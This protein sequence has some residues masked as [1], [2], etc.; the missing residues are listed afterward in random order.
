MEPRRFRLNLPPPISSSAQKEKTGSQRRASD[1]E[2]NLIQARRGSGNVGAGGKVD[3][4]KERLLGADNE[5]D[6]GKQ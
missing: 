6:S 4:G 2:A 1:V 5:E 3:H